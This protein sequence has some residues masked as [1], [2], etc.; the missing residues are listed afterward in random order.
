MDLKFWII[1]WFVIGMIGLTML[2]LQDEDLKI[3]HL[4]FIIIGSWI[5]PII[6]F[7]LLFNKYRNK[8]ILKKRR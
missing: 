7:I 3:S 2:I 4:D 1:L 5:G 8:V 6:I